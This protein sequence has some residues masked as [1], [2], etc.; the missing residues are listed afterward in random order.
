MFATDIDIKNSETTQNLRSS[1]CDS[2]IRALKYKNIGISWNSNKKKSENDLF[3]LENLLES[4]R[5]DNDNETWS[6]LN[7]TIK[8]KKI[9]VYANKYKEQNNLSDD[10]Y[11]KLIYFLRDCLDKKKLQRVKDV[12][13]NRESG[14]ILSIP[15]LFY[16]KNNNHFTLKNLNKK[17]S[18]L[19]SLPPKKSNVGQIYPEMI[20]EINNININ[21]DD[22]ENNV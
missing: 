21:N 1:N 11:D 19:K 22:C 7:K 15:A 14:E 5:I 17:V 16:N 9:L 3:N 12:E 13:Y 6:K 2:Q 8:L 4:E 18:T 10:E 20:D